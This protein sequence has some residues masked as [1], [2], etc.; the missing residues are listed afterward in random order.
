MRVA[1]K[2]RRTFM[3]SGYGRASAPKGVDRALYSPP[4]TFM[5]LPTK[6]TSMGPVAVN[7]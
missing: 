5:D 6:A 2:T 4:G 7:K 3:V 1:K